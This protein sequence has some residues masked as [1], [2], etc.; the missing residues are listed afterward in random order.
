MIK[1]SRQTFSQINR[2][3]LIV[4]IYFCRMPHPTIWITLEST[5]YSKKSFQIKVLAF[6]RTLF[7]LR[8]GELPDFN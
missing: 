4:A 2:Q 8:L 1:H 7:H 6:L 5:I 3:F